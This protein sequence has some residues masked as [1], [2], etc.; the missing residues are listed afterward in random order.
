MWMDSP[1]VKETGISSKESGD[2]NSWQGLAPQVVHHHHHHQQERGFLSQSASLD[3]LEMQL[4]Q[5]KGTAPPLNTS[6]LDHGISQRGSS[7][8]HCTWFPLTP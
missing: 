8:Q 7:D 4:P 1:L 3:V 2:S 6:R 5:H